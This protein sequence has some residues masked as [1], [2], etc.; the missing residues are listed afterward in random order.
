VAFFGGGYNTAQNN[1]H[2]KAFF[3][4]NLATGAMLWEY[5]NDGSSD[6]RQ[7]MNFSIPANP[8]AVDLNGDGYADR[9]YVGDVGGQLWKFDVSATATSSWT[10]KRLFAA[11]PSQ[12]NPPAAGEYY[13]SQAIYGAPSIAF[14]TSLK[15]WVFFGTG[16]RN[17]PNN[18]G[19]NRFY[20]VKDTTTMTNG[21]ALTESNLVEVTSSN[22][23]ATQG[24]FFRL[25]NDEKVLAGANVFNQNV[26]F[27]TFTPTSTITCTSGG[28]AAKLYAVQMG[29]GYAAIDF[30]TGQALT[31]T[32]ASAQRSTATGSGIAGMPMI[33]F[34][35]D[36]QAQGDQVAVITPDSSSGLPDN[37]APA[38]AFL[39]QVRSWRERIQ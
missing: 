12:A 1:A 13:P 31:S 18:T 9:V 4:I 33:V 7:Y 2:G 36:P 32:G 26:F 35:P 34:N 28:G 37:P 11:S 19:T 17:H 30:N 10:G 39:K 29:T 6:D 20:G 27:S 38:P 15:L 8:T 22:A 14:D 16:D 21:A 24:W 25:S 5:Y 23:T 3:A